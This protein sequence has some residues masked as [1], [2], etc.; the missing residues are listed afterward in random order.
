MI[1]KFT[2][3]C[4]SH[5]KSRLNEKCPFNSFRSHPWSYCAP[6]Y[7]LS[8]FNLFIFNI[9]NSMVCRCLFRCSPPQTALCFH[10]IPWLRKLHILEITF[11]LDF[12]TYKCWSQVTYCLGCS[13]IVRT[14][15]LWF[16][17]VALVFPAIKSQS[18]MVESW[19]P[20]RRLSVVS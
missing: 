16:V 20:A 12:N 11:N 8:I 19:L 2:D 1:Q 18:L 4:Q 3:Y 10:I 7:H 17:R 9:F 14:D 15:F 6:I 5:L 13:T